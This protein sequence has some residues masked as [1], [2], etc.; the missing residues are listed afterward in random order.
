[1]TSETETSSL[2][3]RI[4]GFFSNLFKAPPHAAVVRMKGSNFGDM[5]VSREA[6]V[7]IERF[8]KRTS[9]LIR[10]HTR[11]RHGQVS[12]SFTV[13]EG[14][15]KISLRGSAGTA[16]EVTVTPEAPGH[17]ET[18]LRLNRNDSSFRFNFE[19]EG[20]VVGLRGEVSY[21]AT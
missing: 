16:A 8:S 18:N 5:L 13:E 7:T 4:G 14:T 21:K 9:A 10:G 1:V 19:P 20:E 6:T 3:G 2:F 17:M 15:V 12:A 11:R